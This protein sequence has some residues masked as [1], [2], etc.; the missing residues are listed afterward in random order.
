MS[1]KF[2]DVIYL[3]SISNNEIAQDVYHLFN[4]SIGRIICTG[5]MSVIVVKPNVVKPNY[6]RQEDIVKPND[7]RQED[8]VVKSNDATECEYGY[9]YIIYDGQL[10][11]LG[12]T[13]SYLSNWKYADIGEQST[14]QSARWIK[15]EPYVLETS[16]NESYPMTKSLIQ[17]FISKKSGI[18][19]QINKEDVVVNL[20]FEDHGQVDLLKKYSNEQCEV[21]T[22]ILNRLLAAS[23][24]HIHIVY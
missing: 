23:N 4:V 15:S 9:T 18:K 5:Y 10:V 17:M 22:M 11:D 19:L 2:G 16:A 1:V 6:T 3:N 14:I 8:D 12:P 13:F 7:T 20:E 24:E 21:A